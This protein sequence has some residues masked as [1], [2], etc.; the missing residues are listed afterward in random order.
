LFVVR[1]TCFVLDRF[2]RRNKLQAPTG[3]SKPRLKNEKEE[4]SRSVDLR[5]RQN[6]KL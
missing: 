5:K 6:T 1:S 3:I 4:W 2:Y